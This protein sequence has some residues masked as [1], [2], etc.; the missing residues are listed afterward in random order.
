LHS[1]V[2]I[3]GAIRKDGRVVA[4]ASRPIFRSARELGSYYRSALADEL[5]HEGYRI[6]QNTGKDGRYFEIAGVLNAL[7]EALSGR[8]REVARAAERFRARYG[9]ALERGELRGQHQ[10]PDE[11]RVEN[12]TR[13]EITRLDPQGHAT[14]TLDGSQRQIVLS[15]EDLEILRLAYAQHIYRQQ[16]ATVDRAVVLTGGWQTSKESAYVEASRARHGTDW[17]IARDDF[18]NDGNDPDRITRLT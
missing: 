17:Y 8:T 15:G 3:T 7:C 2:V 11:P 12:G 5:R 9:R 10:P 16:G 1:H 13:G 18:G 6:E 4:V 14:I